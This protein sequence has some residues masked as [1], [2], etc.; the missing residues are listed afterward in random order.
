MSPERQD[1]L[2]RQIRDVAAI[3]ARAVGLRLEGDAEEARAELERA[4]AVAS[5]SE[6]QAVL[7]RCLDPSGVAQLLPSAESLAAFAELAREEARQ[8]I[9]PAAGA[10]LTA[11]AEGLLGEARRLDPG[12]EGALRLLQ[13]TGT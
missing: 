13:E 4:Y 2:A 5:G 10:E 12:I 3:L 6:G 1:L 11:R 8:S 7:L 9:D